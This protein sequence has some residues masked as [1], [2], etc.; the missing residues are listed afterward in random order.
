MNIT[1]FNFGAL[2]ALFIVA[3]ATMGC[4]G[5]TSAGLEVVSSNPDE[6]LAREMFANGESVRKTENGVAILA[7]GESL[8]MQMATRKADASLKGA[9]ALRQNAEVESTSRVEGDTRTTTTTIRSGAYLTSRPDWAGVVDVST[10]KRGR[11]RYTALAIV[12]L[13]K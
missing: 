8:D 9:L 1:R 10:D 12:I 11:M 7:T 5:A 3:A 2:V 4:G 6:A 13:A